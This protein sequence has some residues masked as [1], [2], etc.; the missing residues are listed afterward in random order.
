MGE[1]LSVKKR[2]FKILLDISK[3]VSASKMS[4]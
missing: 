3:P 2:K 1:M 4:I